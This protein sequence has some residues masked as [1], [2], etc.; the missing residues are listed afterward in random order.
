[1]LKWNLTNN[2]M[3]QFSVMFYLLNELFHDKIILTQIPSVI[4]FRKLSSALWPNLAA[5]NR[6]LNYQ[7]PRVLVCKKQF[8]L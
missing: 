5:L 4:F 3:G 1:M 7:S 6:L 2:A 8:I